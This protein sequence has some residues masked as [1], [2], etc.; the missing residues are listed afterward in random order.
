M[1]TFVTFYPRD[2]KLSFPGT[3]NFLTLSIPGT[4]NFIQMKMYKTILK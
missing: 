2:R 3:E 4:E 1:K